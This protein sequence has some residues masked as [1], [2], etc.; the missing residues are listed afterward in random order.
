MANP[1]NRSQE[2]SESPDQE[3]GREPGQPE[4]IETIEIRGRRIGGELLEK[5]RRS[6]R[7]VRPP[8]HLYLRE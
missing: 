1:E 8:A 5:C 4:E 6:L 3:T 2:I 7:P